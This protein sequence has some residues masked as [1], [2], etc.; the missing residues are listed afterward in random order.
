MARE[1]DKENG[2]SNGLTGWKER[3]GQAAVHRSSFEE[4][5]AKMGEDNG[6]GM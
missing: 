1:K 3:Y 2:N 4:K 6:G 5:A